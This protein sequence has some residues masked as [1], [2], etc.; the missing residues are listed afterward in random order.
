MSRSGCSPIASAPRP[1]MSMRAL[2]AA[3]AKGPP[4]PIPVRKNTQ[5]QIKQHNFFHIYT[6]S[7]S[8][9][10]SRNSSTWF[11][12]C[13]WQSLNIL[14]SLIMDANRRRPS[15]LTNDAIVWLQHIP[16]P[17]NCERGVSIRNN[18]HSLQTTTSSSHA[19]CE[20]TLLQH[21]NT[22]AGCTATLTPFAQMQSFMEGTELAVGVWHS[23]LHF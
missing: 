19:P 20:R 12:H 11:Y 15:P 13:L 8:H 23:L 7:N 2:A 1:S 10:T 22:T 4:E 9:T 16:V 14:L 5:N 17:R 18:Q 6:F 3:K 21:Y